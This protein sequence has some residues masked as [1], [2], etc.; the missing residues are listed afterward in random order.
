MYFDC[1][2]TILLA[3]LAWS[4]HPLSL[5]LAVRVISSVKEKSISS[6]KIKCSSISLSLDHSTSPAPSVRLIL[7]SLPY[8]W[9]LTA[10][11]PVVNPSLG[12]PD[13]QRVPVSGNDTDEFGTPKIALYLPSAPKLLF[14]SSQLP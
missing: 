5:D 4:F 7:S 3:L 14:S 8:L 9:G 12:F 10:I 11:S 6:I 2:W 13:Q 1:A